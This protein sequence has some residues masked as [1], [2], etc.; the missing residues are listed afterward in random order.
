MNT[1]NDVYIYRDFEKANIRLQEHLSECF[2]CHIK[3]KVK[4]VSEIVK[5]SQSCMKTRYFEELLYKN[6]LHNCLM[7]IIV[8]AKGANRARTNTSN[9]CSLHHVVNSG[10]QN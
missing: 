4:Q 2:A 3:G 1:N 10:K 9:C 6:L 8:H 5:F 7:I